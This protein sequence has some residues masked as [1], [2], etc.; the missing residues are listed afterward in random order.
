MTCWTP[1]FFTCC[2]RLG[3]W[4]PVFCLRCEHSSPE[5]FRGNK[6]VKEMEDEFDESCI[7]VKFI[8]SGFGQGSWARPLIS[9]S[10]WFE[11]LC[12]LSQPQLPSIHVIYTLTDY[13]SLVFVCVFFSLDWFRMVLSSCCFT[14]QPSKK[15]P[16][17]WIRPRDWWEYTQD[18]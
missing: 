14:G 2:L 7:L 15:V 11:H 12:I 17:S 4:S 10:R 3:Y 16:M 13:Y 9:V 8:Q 18:P 6:C 5:D 1:T